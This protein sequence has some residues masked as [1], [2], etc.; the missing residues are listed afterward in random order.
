MAARLDQLAKRLGVG[1]DVL[2]QFKAG[3]LPALQPAIERADVAVAQRGKG[4]RR[5]G[6]E[7]FAGIVN[8]NQDILA[9]QPRPG[10]ER[11]PAGSHVGGKQRMA[12]GKGGL[13][14][15]VQ[16]RDFLAQQ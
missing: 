7:P 3:I 11:N 8:D 10:F 6:D 12:G 4:L 15:H 5:L 2:E 16:Q 14:P 13:V 1:I 9:R